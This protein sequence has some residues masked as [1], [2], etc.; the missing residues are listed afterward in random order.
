M[1]FGQ[2][3]QQVSL[4][5]ASGLRRDELF[6]GL[7][8]IG[9]ANGLGTG[10]FKALAA[11][12]WSGGV[13]NISAIVWFACFA[14]ISLL[15][16]TK[17][18]GSVRPLDIAAATVFLIA[19]A[20]P[21]SE[22]NWIALTGLS[23]YVLLLAPGNPVRRR[24]GMIL[25]ALTV[26]LL[27]SRLLFSFLSKYFL[28]ID[29][30][31]VG[32]LLGT[33][34]TGNVIKFADGSGDMVIMPAC[35]SLANVSLAFLCWVAVSEWIGHRR[36]RQDLLWCLLACLSVVAVNVARMSIMGLSHWHYETF[37]YGWGASLVNI[38]ILGLIVSFTFLG[39]RRELFAR[40]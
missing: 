3:T 32:S 35:S 27:W 12:D 26:P 24:A 28:E 40:V 2:A 37:H 7:F 8:I 6:A 9:C 5:R 15:L 18:D 36:E 25:L 16:Q 10:I 23:F 38:V 30:S 33:D 20:A 17:D 11:G 1:S 34:R 4:S 39:V 13:Q 19:I 21:A 29:A 14:G 22:L 31:L